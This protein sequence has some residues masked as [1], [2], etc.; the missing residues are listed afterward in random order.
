MP[1]LTPDEVEEQLRS[2]YGRMLPGSD[3][4]NGVRAAERRGR[5]LCEWCEREFTPWR[6]SRGRFCSMECFYASIPRPDWW[7]ERPAYPPTDAGILAE[8]RD[9]LARVEA[10]VAEREAESEA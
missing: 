3:Y 1:G 5:S 8:M 10:Y 6:S 9:A 7:Y 2:A 4:R